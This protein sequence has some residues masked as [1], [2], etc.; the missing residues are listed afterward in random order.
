MYMTISHL[1]NS[2]KS[3][4]SG[5]KILDRQ[6]FQFPPDWIYIDHVEG[7]WGAFV[8]I[9]KR[10]DAAVQTQV[11]KGD[12]A[13]SQVIFE[14]VDRIQWLPLSLPMDKITCCKRGTRIGYIIDWTIAS[15]DC[16]RGQSGGA[17]DDRTTSRMGK[18]QA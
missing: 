4:R 11:R 15:K 14:F 12:P 1:R 6:R 7:E 2:V 9:M 17:E 3:F 13:C 18:G 5:E 16:G 10:K 8:E